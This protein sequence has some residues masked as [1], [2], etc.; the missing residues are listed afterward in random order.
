M[1]LFARSGFMIGTILHPFYLFY[2]DRICI[3]LS[4]FQF[5]SQ[6]ILQ[7]QS[8][9]QLGLG[10]WGAMLRLEVQVTNRR[11]NPQEVFGCFDLLF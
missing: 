9:G 4:G 8:S 10:A 5:L 3:G 6:I 2:R 7:P 11:E 1:L